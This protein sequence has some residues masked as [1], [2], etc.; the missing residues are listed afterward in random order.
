M[1][2]AI[3]D[4]L[5]ARGGVQ[6]ALGDAVVGKI[7]AKRASDSQVAGDGS[8]GQGQRSYIGGGCAVRVCAIVFVEA[9]V[10]DLRAIASRVAVSVAVGDQLAPRGCIQFTLGDAASR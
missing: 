2:I 6:F 5:A 4:Q 8:A 1:S 7:A 10:L 3:G 9:T